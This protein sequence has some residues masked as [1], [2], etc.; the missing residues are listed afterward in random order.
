MKGSDVVIG[1][2][3]GTQDNTWIG[4]YYLEAQVAAI[5]QVHLFFPFNFFC[6]FDILSLGCNFVSLHANAA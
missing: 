5:N 4:D 2:S 1:W 3:D 6:S